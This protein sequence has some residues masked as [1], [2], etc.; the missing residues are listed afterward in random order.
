[1]TAAYLVV[2]HRDPVMFRRL[3]AA[4]PADAI[5]YAHI[6]LRADMEP[7][8]AGC[9]AVSFLAERMAPNWASWTMVEVTIRLLE[10]GLADDSVTR[11]T[12]L[13]GQCYPILTPAALTAWQAESIDRLDIVPAPDSAC[14][15]EPWRF[16]RRW[17]GSG[18]RNPHSMY[19]RVLGAAIRRFG[20]R[21]DPSAALAGRSLFAGSAWWS[22]TRRTAERA[23]EVA[24]SDHAL[25]DYFSHTFCP[26]ESFWHTAVAGSLDFATLGCEPTYVKWTG[27]AHPAPLTPEDLI[28]EAA[29]GRFAF[30]RKFFSDQVELL[31]L[32]DRLRRAET[33]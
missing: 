31:D 7:F 12:L 22:F 8:T 24:R 33:P 18:F 9:P 4:L 6:D 25:T 14:D 11:Y 28:R 19:A 27:G 29:R 2:A 3:V 20:L 26:D 32:V 17:S 23:C 16:Q 21:V 30:A 13:S 1:M 10:A 15:K 5:V